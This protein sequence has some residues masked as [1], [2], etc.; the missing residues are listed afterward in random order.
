[1]SALSPMFQSG[2]SLS[3]CLHPRFYTNQRQGEHRFRHQ[4]EYLP[5]H[6]EDYQKRYREDPHLF[7]S[8]ISLSI[9]LHYWDDLHNIDIG[10]AVSIRHQPEYLPSR[11]QRETP[12]GVPRGVSIRHQPEYLP[13]PMTHELF[14][15]WQYS[16]KFQSG[17]SLSICLHGQGKVVVH[18]YEGGFQSGISLSI[19]LHPK[20]FKWVG[21][22]IC[23]FQSGISLSICLHAPTMTPYLTIR[24]RF[25]QAS[26]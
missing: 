15:D 14:H 12:Q 26:A 7:Q 1:M 19:C 17:I 2:I 4:P 18:S 10:V 25:N 20:R 9:C 5:S 24:V 13:S 21:S 23:G 16:R 3:I 11:H 8:G 6:R 22:T